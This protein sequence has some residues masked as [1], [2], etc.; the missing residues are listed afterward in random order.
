[1]TGEESGGED[2]ETMA[3]SSSGGTGT[4]GA[5]GKNSRFNNHNSHSHSHSH[6]YRDTNRD[7]DRDKD[8]SKSKKSTNIQNLEAGILE[9]IFSYLQLGDVRNC[10]LVCSTWRRILLDG[11]GEVWRGLA[12]TILPEEAI[13][14]D[15][16]ATLPDYRAKLRAFYHAWNPNDSSRNI[17]I[18][19]NGFTLHRYVFLWITF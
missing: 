9:M 16:L 12:N 15:L 5:A 2:W 18:K 19:A 1:V 10:I 17:Y 4:P 11:D 6:H 14:S 3:S 8:K 7:R 13:K